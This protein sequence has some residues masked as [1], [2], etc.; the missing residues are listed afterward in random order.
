[1]SIILANAG[2]SSLRKKKFHK[3]QR[4]WI[5]GLFFPMH[6]AKNNILIAFV[7]DDERLDWVT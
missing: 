7:V 4:N 6:S 5:S 2:C 3:P 1:M